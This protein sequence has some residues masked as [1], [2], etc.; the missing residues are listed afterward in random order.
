MALPVEKGGLLLL[1]YL[2][3]N[4]EGKSPLQLAAENGYAE[5]VEFL[6]S[7]WMRVPVE[8]LSE[9]IPK[10]IKKLIGNHEN[11]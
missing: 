1:R 8:D 9:N 11:K 7:H 10:G 5:I 6:L 4:L 2:A 3:R